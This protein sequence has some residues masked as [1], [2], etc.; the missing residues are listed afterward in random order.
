MVK[1]KIFLSGGHGNLTAG[2]RSPDGKLREY[3]FNNPTTQAF[4][5]IMEQYENVEVIHVN[6][7]KGVD[8]PLKAR[9][10]VANAFYN[11]NKGDVEKGKVKVYYM[12][13]HANAMGDKWQTKATGSESLVY[14][15]F[16]EA[17][18]LAQLIEQETSKLTKLKSRGIKV[19]PDL[20]ELRETAMPAVLYEAA[21]MDNPEDFKLLMSDSFRIT[22]AQGV[23]NAFVKHLGL[24]KKDS[25]PAPAPSPTPTPAPT[26][27]NKP[28]NGGTSGGATNE[29]Y[30]VQVGAFSSQE[31]AEA[32][33]KELEKAGFPAIIKQG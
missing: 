28:N 27:Q 2:K 5:K 31:N 8:T 4:K 29:L 30:Y 18:K 15:A 21:F 19:R 25:K 12:S 13:F 24:K 22:V 17:A 9:T 23:A 10:N 11:R 1:V 3:H 26:P 32:R 6:D 7:L 14:A 16:G 33:K 20:H